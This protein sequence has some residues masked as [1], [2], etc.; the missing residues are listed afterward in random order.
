MTATTIGPATAPEPAPE[1]QP[2][3]RMLRRQGWPFDADRRREDLGFFGPESPTWKVWT[4]P[5]ALIGFQRAVV[6]EHFDPFLTAAVADSRGIFTDPR[7]RLDSTLAYFLIAA[8]CDS[9]TAVEAS[10]LLM[11][12]HARATGVEPISGRRYSANN[13]DSQLWIHV[14]GWQ[15]VLK[16]YEAYGPGRLSAEDEKRYWA[17]CVTAAELQTCKASDVPA[18]R[19]EVREY[20]ARVRSR[21]CSSEKALEG[22]HYLLR[23]PYSRGGFELWA[24]SRLMAPATIATLPGWMRRVGNFDQIRLVDKAVK[25]PTK[26]AVFAARPPRNALMA[27]RRT[28]PMTHAILKQHHFGEAPL[29]N[30]TVTPARARELHGSLGVRVS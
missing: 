8:V 9:R 2:E 5:T 26:A 23:T 12:V 25:L 14:T 24:M 22:M 7:G 11:R 18:S 6:L 21:L 4:H 27:I 30:R 29:E 3:P 1:P 13:P 10:E 28:L 15:S 20:Y 19:E 17:D 16:C